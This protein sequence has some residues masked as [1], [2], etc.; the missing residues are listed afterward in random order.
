VIEEA[1][2]EQ[3]I[4]VVHQAFELDKLPLPTEDAYVE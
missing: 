3:G 1:H 4:K 2:L